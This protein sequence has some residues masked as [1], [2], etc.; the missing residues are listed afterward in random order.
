[1]G[2]RKTSSSAIETR[3]MASNHTAIYFIGD[4]RL[5]L[6]YASVMSLL[7]NSSF[8]LPDMH[9]P[10]NLDNQNKISQK[11]EIYYK[12][13]NYLGNLNQILLDIVVKEDKIRPSFI[14]IGTGAW[15]MRHQ[16]LTN[17]TETVFNIR[18]TIESLKV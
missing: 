15:F 14:F 11:T 2:T 6:L 3:E 16:T 1:M 13:D 12:A 7:S 5:R 18:N 10:K 9:I 8:T 17:Y 4:S